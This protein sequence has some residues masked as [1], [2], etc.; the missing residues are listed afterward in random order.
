MLLFAESQLLGFASCCFVLC[1]VCLCVCLFVVFDAVL[2]LCVC[3]FVELTMDGICF[4]WFVLVC[5]SN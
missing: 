4:A 3:L 2:C 5:G 1:V